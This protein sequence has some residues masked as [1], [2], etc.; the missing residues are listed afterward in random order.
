MLKAWIVL[1]ILWAAGVAYFGWS[2]WPTIPL[3]VSAD[4]PATRA[5]FDGAVQAHVLEYALLALAPPAVLLVL[6]RL[7]LRN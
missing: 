3:D 4:D 5:A 6:G 7:L 2:N 1:S